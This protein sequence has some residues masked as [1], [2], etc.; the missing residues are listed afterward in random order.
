MY[1]KRIK[2]VFLNMTIKTRYEEAAVCK[3]FHR[4]KYVIEKKL[5][6]ILPKRSYK[7]CVQGLKNILPTLENILKDFF[8]HNQGC[9]SIYLTVKSPV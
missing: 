9:N 6:Y 4:W 5:A 2:C 1:Q 7:V 3:Q 8:T